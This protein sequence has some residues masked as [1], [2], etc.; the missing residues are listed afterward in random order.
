MFGE[1]PEPEMVLNM[2]F[3]KK[4]SEFI[5]DLSNS[6]ICWKPE[7]LE[8]ITKVVYRRIT[9][10]LTELAEFGRSRM[11]NEAERRHDKS[12][13]EFRMIS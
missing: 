12:Y 1:V 5:T 7:Q 9:V 11:R 4:V 3:I 2:G 8:I 10:L 6:L 13:R